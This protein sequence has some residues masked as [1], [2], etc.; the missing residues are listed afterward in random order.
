MD[1]YTTHVLSHVIANHTYIHTISK[2]YGN[3]H[4]THTDTPPLLPSL[5]ALIL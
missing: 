2:L 3:I 4:I 1:K 5:L